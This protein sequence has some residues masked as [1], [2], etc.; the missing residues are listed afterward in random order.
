MI[1]VLPSHVALKSLLLPSIH[2]FEK[3]YGSLEVFEKAMV[4]AD[5]KRRFNYSEQPILNN[6]E[7]TVFVDSRE[8]LPLH[9]KN[10][11]PLKLSVGD[12][13]PNKEFYSDVYVDR[14][15]LNDLAGTL[16]SGRERVEREIE[17]AK[18]L[19]FYLV[20]VVEDLYSNTLNYTSMNPFAKKYN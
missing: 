18:S 13:A 16:T 15:S 8:Q 10:S 12:Y 4:V 3:M 1:T 11:K 5:I 20:F 7:I 14:K 2:G 6:G 19:G 9:F 17:R